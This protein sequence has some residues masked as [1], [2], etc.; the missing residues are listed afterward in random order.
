MINVIDGDDQNGGGGG[1]RDDNDDDDHDDDDHH[2]HHHHHHHHDDHDD[3]QSVLSLALLE[4][5][6]TWGIENV[7]FGTALMTTELVPH[8]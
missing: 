5:L 2:H 8:A 3:H 7:I 4:T 6:Y 1:G